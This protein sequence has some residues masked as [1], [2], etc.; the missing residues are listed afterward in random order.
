MKG[1]GSELAEKVS[2]LVRQGGAGRA[3]AVLRN[4]GRELAD[5]VLGRKAERR[6]MRLAACVAWSHW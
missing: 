3:V 1:G 5:G 4:A 6:G 2:L